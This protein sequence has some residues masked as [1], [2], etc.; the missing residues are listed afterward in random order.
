MNILDAQIDWREDVGNDPRLEVLVDETPERSE[1]RFEHED[2]LWTAIDNGYVEYFAW[3]GDG[4]DGGFSG[5]SFEI[6]TVD[7]EQVT[8]EGPWS[9]RA[10]CVNKRRFGPVVDVRMATDPSVLEKGY[11]FRTGTLTLSAAKQA[12][13]LADEDVHFKRVEKFD[14]N[15]PYWVP[16]Q[17]DRG[18][19]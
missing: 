2:S 4:N 12:I 16:V 7:G 19:V 14:S 3:S 1:L 10:G 18:D 6:T 15:E 17:D 11:T 5:R 8:L 13:D 9:S